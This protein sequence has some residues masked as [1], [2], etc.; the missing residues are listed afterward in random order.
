MGRARFDKRDHVEKMN[1]LF[2]SRNK[3]SIMTE[4]LGTNSYGCDLSCVNTSDSG[5]DNMVMNGGGPNSIQPY[6]AT[7]TYAP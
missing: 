4:Q 3:R 1:R 6:D 5:T 7:T 2:E